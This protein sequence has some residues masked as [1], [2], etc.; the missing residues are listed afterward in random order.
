MFEL[1]GPNLYHIPI[2]PS[3]P[4]ISNH[5]PHVTCT[6]PGNQLGHCMICWT[7]GSMTCQSVFLLSSHRIYTVTYWCNSDETSTKLTPCAPLPL[8]TII[9]T[10]WLN[11]LCWAPTAVL[12][13]LCEVPLICLWLSARYM[14][15]SMP[16]ESRTS[17]KTI[18]LLSAKIANSRNFSGNLRS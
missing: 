9:C 13:L 1:T 7:N 14:R 10:K 3:F 4:G 2:M 5:S 15:R 11:S 12:G 6:P 18:W 8:I 17:R 16:F